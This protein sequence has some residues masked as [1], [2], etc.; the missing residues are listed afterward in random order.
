MKTIDRSSAEHY[1]WGGVCD[2]WHLVKRQD[3]SVIAERI[4]PGAGETR[5][6]HSIARQFFYV[7]SGQAV[8]MIDGDALTLEAGQGIEVAP[9]TPHRIGNDSPGDVHFLVISHPTTRGD[10]IDR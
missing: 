3:L 6:F 4:P 7:L 8:M 2:G 5:H 9:G 1:L 10:R